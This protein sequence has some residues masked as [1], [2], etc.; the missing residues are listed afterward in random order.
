MRFT[1]VSD[2]LVPGLVVAVVVHLVVRVG[3]G[4]LPPLPRLA[5]STLLMFAIVEVVLGLMLR[6]KI[7]AGTVR[8]GQA[9]TVARALALAKASSLVGAVML[10]AWSGV[11]AYTVP[12]R[13]TLEAAAGDT[14]GALIGALCAVALLGAGLWLEHCCRTPGDQH[15]IHGDTP[16]T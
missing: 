8:P 4:D 7:R 6:S 10:G 9:I 11:L 5:G 14:I 13:A 15:E 16:G 2:L 1:S 3:Y 12:L